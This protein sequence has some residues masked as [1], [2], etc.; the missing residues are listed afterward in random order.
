MPRLALQSIVDA[1]SPADMSD[2]L[3]TVVDGNPTTIA[4]GST[5]NGATIS[6]AYVAD[7]LHDIHVDIY[8][9]ADSRVVSRI[10]RLL[11]GTGAPKVETYHRTGTVMVRSKGA[12]TPLPAS[13]SATSDGAMHFVWTVA[14]TQGASTP[15]LPPA[16][17]ATPAPAPTAAPSIKVA[18]APASKRG[19]F[20]VPPRSTTHRIITPVAAD[21]EMLDASWALHKM[22]KP[23]AVMLE[24]PA[25]TGKTSIVDD[26]A[27]DQQVGVFTFDGAA[28]GSWA[29]WT[30]TTVL[31]DGDKGTVTHFAWSSFIE[32]I[33]KDGPEAGVPRIVLVD[34][35]NRAES[36]AANNALMPIM[37]Q[38]RLYVP[39]AD[40][41]VF[42]DPLVM[43]V[44]TMNRG[45]AGTQA[46]DHALAD[47]MWTN[48]RM[49]YLPADKEVALVTDRVAGISEEQAT[50]LV[51]AARQVRDM[52]EAGNLTEA[53][54]TRSVLMAAEYVAVGR[55][56]RQ[57]ATYC[58]ANGFD[59]AGG[60]ESDR[61]QVLQAVF[62]ILP[63]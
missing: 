13:M 32:A 2:A 25:G 54:S 28:A 12:P 42:V 19:L 43:F 50:L 53:V 6:L 21:R 3:T 8:A 9:G 34:E 33:R 44:F 5:S 7:I 61:G 52:A 26:F 11:Q 15:T 46:L 4:I 56:L 38:G 47:R 31:R 37:S 27:A 18:A 14:P 20:T 10:N 35:L 48:I 60:A 41:T 22:G 40:E 62:N 57:A 24:G 16:I 58:W 59:A 63:E 49:D 30:G 55:S 29:D 45:Y 39:E 36:A 1:Q 23:V 17:P 51:R